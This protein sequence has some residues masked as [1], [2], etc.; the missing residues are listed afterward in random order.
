MTIQ[1]RFNA[2]S[3]AFEVIQGHDLSAKT[4]LITGA[5]SGIGIETAR[6]LLH[7]GANVILAVRDARKGATVAQELREST[8]NRRISVLL[9]DLTSL[10]SIRQAVAQC[11][12]QWPKLD[13][14]INNA[15][16][17]AAPQG[18]TGDGF[19]MHFGIN[20]VGHFLLTSL[21]LPALL[22]ATPSRVVALSSSG[23]R[24]SGIHWEDI[25]YRF[26]PY[27]RWSA[28]GQSKTA[29]ALFAVG[30]TQRY[31][32]SGVTANA[33]HPGGVLNTGLQKYVS[34]EEQR[35]LGWVDAAGNPNPIVKTV[36]QGA[37]TT[38]WAAVAPELAGIGGLYLED[39]HEAEVIS[40]DNAN[41]GNRYVGYMAYARSPEDA[42]R[43]WCVTD[44][45]LR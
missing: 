28:Y 3:T 18:M 29:N 13:I 22:A 4:V 38:V 33:V 25:N 9:L 15:G 23:H 45:M 41:T 10:A 8:G 2:R 6:A 21:L 43:L 27:D 16:I 14:L 32:S 7:A 30:F 20:H 34:P 37:S 1:S 40:P 36:E 11:L 17:A 44:D 42:E 31:G 19:E 39:C 5:S 12:Q 24:L 26:R 35:A